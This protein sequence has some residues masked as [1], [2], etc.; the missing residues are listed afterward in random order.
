MEKISI[1]VLEEF[2]EITFG[3]S[4]TMVLAEVLRSEYSDE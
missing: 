4:S 2:V 3:A 1:M